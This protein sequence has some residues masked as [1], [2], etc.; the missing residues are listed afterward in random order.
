[1]DLDIL[2]YSRYYSVYRVDYHL[3]FVVPSGE[4]KIIMLDGSRSFLD[5]VRGRLFEQ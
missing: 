5:K 4:L 2:A 1:V 3:L